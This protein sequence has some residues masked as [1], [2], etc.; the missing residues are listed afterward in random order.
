M[1]RR[2]HSNLL[3]LETL[4]VRFVLATFTD[5]GFD[6]SGGGAAW[7]DYNN[8]GWI[9]CDCSRSA[10]GSGRQFRSQF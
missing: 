8:D 3:R 9:E 10:P 2:I 7:G 4:E 5:T 1:K 6:I